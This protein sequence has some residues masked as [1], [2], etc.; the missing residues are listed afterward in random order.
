[1][2]KTEPKKKPTPAS[3]Y[4]KQDIRAAVEAIAAAEGV[5]VHS[6]MAYGIAYFVKQYQAGKVKL[7]VEERPKRLKLD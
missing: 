4:L 6:V 2:T 5:T 3:V 1:M 7:K